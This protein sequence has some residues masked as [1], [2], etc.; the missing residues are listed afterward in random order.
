VDPDSL[1]CDRRFDCVFVMSLFTHL[2]ERTFIRWLSKLYSLISEGG[3]LIFTVHDESLNPALKIPPGGLWFKEE[4]EIDT[5]SKLDYG[6]T[7]VGEAFVRMAIEQATQGKGTYLR[8]PR[9]VN[10]YQDMYIVMNGI[11]SALLEFNYS[12]GPVG[13]L[14]VCNLSAARLLNVSGWT[15]DITPNRKIEEIQIVIDG[16]LVQRCLPFAPRPDVEAVLNNPRLA[17]S[18]FS[19]YCP[20]PEGASNSSTLSVNVVSETGLNSVLYHDRL[21]IVRG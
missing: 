14:E 2:P 8:V 10:T 19:C 11:P 3:V 17:K 15:G 7:V 16:E 13:H 18:G 12:W 9:A 6:T 20:I 1:E 21:G 5:I 4:S